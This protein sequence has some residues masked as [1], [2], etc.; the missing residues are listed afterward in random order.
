MRA[1]SPNSPSVAELHAAEGSGLAP[2][3]LAWAIGGRPAD[4]RGRGDARAA[5]GRAGAAGAR[6][7]A[8]RPCASTGTKR[9][10]R[11]SSR[12][13]LAQ[14]GDVLARQHHGADAGAER[15]ERLLAHAAD[16]QHAAAQRHLAGH[17]DV[18]AHGD[19]GRERDERRGDRDAR[20]GAVLRDARPPARA[21]GSGG[22][23]AAPSSRPRSASRQRAKV[24]AAWPDSFITSPS[25]PVS[26]RPRPAVSAT[27][28]RSTSPP[29]SVQASP[30]A[31][32]TCDSAAAGS[33]RMAR[34]PEQAVEAAA[35]HAHR[36]LRRP[37]R[38]GAR[39][40]GRSP[41][42][43]ARGRA[44]RPRRCT[45]SRCRAPRRATSG[46]GRRAARRASVWRGIRNERAISTFS[47]GV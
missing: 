42:S 19:A 15:G 37:R 22:A 32:P 41:R 3:R 10:R 33:P 34:R 28:T 36:A 8:P 46:C 17:R 4:A 24:S 13:H 26:T 25:W 45:R 44:R 23:R 6:R 5:A 9:M 29:V 47:S 38:R 7:R 11:A 21:R 12:R 31:T 30:F 27:S 35:R 16:R 14:I 2:C 20:R 43:G 1:I 39:P 40:C 18:V